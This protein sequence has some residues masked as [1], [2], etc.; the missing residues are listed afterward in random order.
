KDNELSEGEKS[1]KV[2]AG[3][4]AGNKN[5]TT[6]SIITDTISPE[7]PTIELDHSSDSGIKNDNITNCSLRTFIGVAQP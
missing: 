1:I 2:V 4:K 5:E 3:D 7:K 6:D